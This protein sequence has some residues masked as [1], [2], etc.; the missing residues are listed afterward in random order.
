[1]SKHR[2]DPYEQLLNVMEGY[3]ADGEPRGA[4][5]ALEGG[6]NAVGQIGLMLA[7]LFRDFNQHIPDEMER[8]QVRTAII[9]VFLRWLKLTRITSHFRLRQ[10][11][12]RVC[13]PSTH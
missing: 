6:N 10:M 5:V 1:M 12:K 2:P 3:T 13:L 8:D 11:L 9:L 7:A 4:P